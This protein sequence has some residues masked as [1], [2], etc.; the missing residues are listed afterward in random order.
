MSCRARVLW[1][2][3]ADYKM[4]GALT[5]RTDQFRFPHFAET[6]C[7]VIERMRVQPLK[8]APIGNLHITVGTRGDANFVCQLHKKP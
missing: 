2:Y 6:L 3:S 1:Q 4:G 7:Q 5:A 8:L